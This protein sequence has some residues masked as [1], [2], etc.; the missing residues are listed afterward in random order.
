MDILSNE[1]A[2]FFLIV[3]LGLIL[4]NIKIKGISLESSGVI[5]VALAFGHY[6]FKTPELLQNIGLVLF[7][8]SVGIAAGPGFFK[9]LKEQGLNFIFLAA[10]IVFSGGIVTLGLS[11][12]T[13]TDVKL[14]VG[15]FT[16]AMTST[17]GLA[18]AID[19]SK[20]PLASI[21]YGIAYPFGV[22]GVIIFVRL[23]NKFVKVDISDSEKEYELSLKKENPDI[24][25][26]NFKVTN[27]NIFGK[28]IG[29]LDIR[30][31][32]GTNI[33]RVFHNSITI[34][35]NASTPLNEGDIVKAVGSVSDLEKVRIL[36]GEETDIKIPLSK[37]YIVKSILVSN[38]KISNKTFS[39]LHLFANYEA[40][41]TC[42]RRAGID[43][44]P[45]ASTKIQLGDKVMIAC[46]KNNLKEIE[47]FFGHHGRS[48]QLD[49]L[50]IAIGIIL[51]ILIGQI[52]IPIGK[53]VFS[54]GVTGGVLLSS[55][56][57][58][59]LGRTGP[60][61]WNVAGE[62]NQFLRKIGLVFFLVGVGTNAGEHLIETLQKNGIELFLLGAVITIIPMILA[63]YFSK[64][65]LKMNFLLFLGALTGGMTSTPALSALE[66][67]TDSEAPKIGYATI[68][69]FALVFM[70]IVSQIICLFA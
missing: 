2:V 55:L 59:K 5:F 10:I 47:S 52:K 21:G 67:M 8:Y 28:A 27:P 32:T 61:L 63:L 41:A 35:P 7:I 43:I 26:R 15:L 37:D 46:P 14:A 4:G 60:L 24:F 64:Y 38:S 62:V 12:L 58:S 18:A 16:G 51:G 49:L 48:M 6:G 25:N 20:S 68:Y 29:E 34:T 70:I 45:K 39:D 1:Y 65:V 22:L 40:T 36:I 44:T 54:L 17:P 9:S 11:F 13:N 30:T 57:L 53:A 23:I 3:A 19:A 33:S 69:P 66:P 42:I 56:L 50:P 31:M